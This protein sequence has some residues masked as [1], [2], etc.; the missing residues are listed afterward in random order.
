MPCLILRWRGRVF[1]PAPDFQATHASTDFVRAISVP[2]WPCRNQKCFLP[3][4]EVTIL[5]RP[6]PHC[7][8]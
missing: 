2:W 5:G 6:C 4:D 7:R 3:F 1:S 8:L